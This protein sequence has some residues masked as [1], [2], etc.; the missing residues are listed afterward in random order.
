M[1]IFLRKL[2]RPIKNILIS[3]TDRIGDFILTLPVFEALK[4]ETDV[5]ITVL[6]QKMVAPLIQNNPFIDRV[7]T[8]E[9]EKSDVDLI[10]EIKSF[11]F[12]SLLVLVND[13]VIRR[14]IAQLKFIPVRIG[15]LSKPQMLFNYTHPVIQ[16]RSQSFQNEAEYNLELIRQITGAIPQPIKPKLY[17]EDEEKEQFQKKFPKIDQFTQ[18]GKTI[19]LHCGMNNSALNWSFGSYSDLLKRLIDRNFHIILTGASDIENETNQTLINGLPE[20]SQKNVLNGCGKLN[21]RELAVLLSNCSLFIGP[22]TGPT[23]VANATGIPVVSIYPPIQVQS[24]QRWQPFLAQSEILVPN[25]PCGQK[26]RCIEKKCADYYC[27]DLIT[28]E[29]VEKAVLRLL[30]K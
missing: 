13:P 10:S 9:S 6:C 5:Q 28:S 14:L 17:I 21:L 27:L 26:Y 3:R 22:S 1:A 25:V 24:K 15:P 18:I 16:K 23:H 2:K 4:K 29:T 19:V 11:A 20:T 7:I 8:V 30:E 12:D